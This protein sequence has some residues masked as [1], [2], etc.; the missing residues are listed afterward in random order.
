[1]GMMSVLIAMAAGLQSQPATS[2]PADVGA[3]SIAWRPSVEAAVS[4]ARTSGRFAAVYFHN[5]WCI[6]SIRLNRE[7]L[8]DPGVVVM[9]ER[10]VPC[11]VNYDRERALVRRYRVAGHPTIVF[12]DG[13]GRAV[14]RFSGYMPPREFMRE[15]NAHLEYLY[16]RPGLEERLKQDADDAEALNRLA[17]IHAERREFDTARELI[18]RA[19]AVDP[20][21]AGHV[22]L[23]AYL[24]FARDAESRD[25]KAEGLLWYGKALPAQT[26][27]A[28]AAEI[29][30]AMG[31]MLARRGDHAEAREHLQAVVENPAASAEL[32]KRAGEY[33]DR[34]EQRERK[35]M[36]RLLFDSSDESKGGGAASEDGKE[37]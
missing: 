29:H 35:M 21:D 31:H 6:Y 17:V 24:S 14:D 25:D 22:R 28:E 34:I 1:M 37:N 13:E 12:L 30:L 20:R 7:T 32:R 4:E 19:E 18:A 11:R 3:P 27:P 36:E 16:D 5:D 26:D 9:F 2:Q 23:R 8:V 33:L 15:M 10:F